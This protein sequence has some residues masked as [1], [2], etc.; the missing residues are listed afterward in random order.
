MM[1]STGWQ[2]TQTLRGHERLIGRFSWSP[3]QTRVVTPGGEG[4]LVVWDSASGT[5]QVAE[6]LAR[7]L[8]AVAWSADGQTLAVVGSASWPLQSRDPDLDLEVEFPES[9][10]ED[11]LLE[12]FGSQAV[13]ETVVVPQDSD[14]PIYI[15]LID[16]DSGL[17]VG[18]LS[19]SSVTQLPWDVHWLLDGQHLVSASEE[20]LA[21]WHARDGYFL[22]FLEDSHNQMVGTAFAFSDEQQ[23]VASGLGSGKIGIWSAQSGEL[24]QQLTGDHVAPYCAAFAAQS[25]RFAIGDSGGGVWVWDTTQRDSEPHL[26]EAHTNA[27]TGISLSRD[28]RLLAT[29]SVDATIRVWDLSA[30]ALLATHRD[31]SMRDVVGRVAFRDEDQRETQLLAGLAESGRALAMWQLHLPALA[32]RQGRPKTV[33]YANAKVVLLGDSGVGK[34]GLGLVL[35]GQSFRPTDSTHQRNV[36]LLVSEQ[37]S[38]DPPEYHEVY[39]WD[40]AGSPDTAYFISFTYLM[41]RWHWWSSMPEMRW[42]HLRG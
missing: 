19:T 26:L 3:D 30:W 14:G 36:W 8:H 32:A 27:V 23:V 13:R 38:G 25:D 29:A 7:S 6:T 10:Y 2:R 20:G 33:H 11:E 17:Q 22:G 31:R 41:L 16:A 21:L 5:A 37:V 39:L 34:T 42:I 4:R 18:T 28:G 40:L 15:R 1:A 35:S 24:I 9:A 12:A